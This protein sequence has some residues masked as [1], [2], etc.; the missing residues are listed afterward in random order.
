MQR[1]YKAMANRQNVLLYTVF[2]KLKEAFL[3]MKNVIANHQ[4]IHA[5]P[6]PF[7]PTSDSSA[8]EQCHPSLVWVELPCEVPGVFLRITLA[9]V[10]NKVIENGGRGVS[11]IDLNESGVLSPASHICKLRRKGALIRTDLKDAYDAHGR[12]HP[13]VAHYV[14]EGWEFNA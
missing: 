2:H 9:E 8:E 5:A 7:F 4:K 13:Q 1:G 10:L 11:T 3:A 12:K 6:T 14:Y